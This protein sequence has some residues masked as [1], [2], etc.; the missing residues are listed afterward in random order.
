MEISS[1]YCVD[2]APDPGAVM[3]AFQLTDSS[4]LRNVVDPQHPAGRRIDTSQ[5]V[6]TPTQSES[7]LENV[8]RWFHAHRFYAYGIARYGRGLIWK[9][10]RWRSPALLQFIEESQADI[11]LCP[12]YYSDHLLELA[13]IVK[14]VSGVPMVGY[15]SDDVYSLRQFSLSPIFWIERF[16]KRRLIRQLVARCEWIYV[17]SDV[18]KAD[19]ERQLG[20]ECPVL[21]KLGEFSDRS[22]P[23]ARSVSPDGM[24]VFTYAGNIGNER[25]RSL[26]QLGKAIAEV[27]RQ[28]MHARLDIYTM[29]PLT[30]R[31]RRALLIEGAVYVHHA[32]GRNGLN[33][34]YAE[35]D[36]LVLVE[37]TG[38]RGRLSVR[39]SLS[40]KVIEYMEAGRCMFAFGTQDMASIS[41]LHENR[42]ALTATPA[43]DLA[44]LIAQL[45]SDRSLRE[46]Y[47]LNAWRL[48]LERHDQTTVGARVRDE[49]RSLLEDG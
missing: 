5:G 37:P 42:V 20:V 18:Q 12:I 41:Y 3:R 34:V 28:G 24:V 29:T 30:S 8:V 27:N 22:L 10:G 15:V 17:V 14:D 16:H 26:A 46:E 38:L 1:I 48:G 9:V 44:S 13:R 11:I 19:Y 31:M 23:L 35:S 39:H 45:V 21:T 43:D 7:A 49:L 33:E 40:T 6:G 4:V 25:W 2:G 32:V 36:V 47:A